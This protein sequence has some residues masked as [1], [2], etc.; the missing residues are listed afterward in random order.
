M[1]PYIYSRKQFT[2]ETN[3]QIIINAKPTRVE[4]KILSKIEM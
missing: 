2:F 4:F 1:F 3:V